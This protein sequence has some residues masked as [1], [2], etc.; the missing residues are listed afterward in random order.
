MADNHTERQTGELV[1]LDEKE[2]YPNFQ[3]DG[4][5][6]DGKKVDGGELRM[7]TFITCA[8]G[9]SGALNHNTSVVASIRNMFFTSSSK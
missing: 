6:D 3:G 4:S 7:C 2:I 5:V 9:S 8:A 1:M